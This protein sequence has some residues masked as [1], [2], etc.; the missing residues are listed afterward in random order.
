MA[1]EFAADGRTGARDDDGEAYQP[2]RREY[3]PAALINYENE[4]ERRTPNLDLHAYRSP[5]ELAPFEWHLGKN[6]RAS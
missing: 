4:P 3:L 1:D 6:K 2:A 5:A